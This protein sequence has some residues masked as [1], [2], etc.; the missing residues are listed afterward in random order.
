L[1]KFNYSSYKKI[2]KGWSNDRKFFV[3]NTD[4]RCFLRISSIDNYE[5]KKM[6]FAMMQK[7]CK[8]NIPMCRPIKFGKIENEVYVL[9]SW[10]NG[11][12]LAEVIQD[13]SKQKQY[14]YGIR[15][16]EALRKIHSLPAPAEIEPWELRYNHKL[17]KKIKNYNSCTLK[18]SQGELFLKFVNENRHL[19]KNRPQSFQHGDYH[20][21]NFMLDDNNDLVIVD[22]DRF[23][24]GDPWEEFNRIVWSAKS[25][26]VFAS[27]IINGYFGDEV[28]FDFWKLLKLYIFSN[29]LSSLP[30]AIPFGSDEVNTM[31]N[32]AN[33]ILE[34]Y[35]NLNEDIPSWYFKAL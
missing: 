32:Q 17:D 3:E 6:E 35:N 26:P 30:W 2:E 7:L 20:I 12:D 25:S 31:I 34:W 5:R 8:L 15:A 11:K 27:G 4:G 19:L 23:D 9:L 14:D 28:P 22:F 16:G 21:S 18:Y 24:F 10:I 29:T 33:D 13:L 1:E